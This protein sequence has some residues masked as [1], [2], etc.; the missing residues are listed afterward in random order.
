MS[1][2][3]PINDHRLP[4]GG[5]IDRQRQK[6]FVF[7]GR[8]YCGYEGDTLAS[9]LLANGVHLAGR[10]F[11]YHR[12]RGIFSDGPE[13]PNALVEMRIG[14]RR[15]PNTRATMVELYDG[16][17]ANS[18][19]R[20]PALSFDLQA[21]NQWLSPG[22]VAGFYYKTF[23]WPKKGWMFYEH[24]IR[25]AAGLG[26]ATLEPD[27][28]L[29]EKV[30]AHCDVLVIGGGPAGIAA[31][32]AAGRAGARV[33]LCDERPDLGGT[34]RYEEREIDGKPAL[35][36]AGGHLAELAGMPDVTVLRRTTAFGTY[37]GNTVGLV[38]RVSDHL[39]TP[40]P[41][42]VRQR[43]WTVRAKKIVLATGAIERPLVF[44]NNDKPGV[45]LAS[46][47]R[48]YIRQY[49]VKPGERAVLFATN[50][51]AYRT[52][53]ALNEAGAGVTV[54]DPRGEHGTAW[55]ERVRDAGIEVLTGHVITSLKGRLRV[56]EV[57][58][59]ESDGRGH[60]G[61]PRP[62]AADLV[63]V[64]G[65]WAPTL[66]LATHAGAKAT[67]DEERGSFVPD[68]TKCRADMTVVGSANG[69]NTLSGAIEEGFATGA[70]AA[71][72]VGKSAPDPIS[73]E[74]DDPAEAP[75]RSLWKVEPAQGQPSKSFV[76]L[77]NDATAKD[78]EIANREGYI[79]VEHMKRYTT[80]GMATDQGKTANVNGLALLAEARGQSIPDV[81]TTTFRPPYTPVTLGAM[82]GRHTAKHYKPIRRT[83]MH[84]WHTDAGAVFVE[85]GLWLRPQYYPRPGED[86]HAAMRREVKMTRN[87]VGLCDV[88]TLGKID[89][90]GPDAAEF[91]NR[92]YSNGFKTLAVGKARYGLMLREDGIVY[93]DGTTSRLGEN[94]YLMTTTTGHAVEVM[95]LL[96][97]YAQVLW[98]ELDVQLTSVT[99][100]WAAIAVAGPK[101]R[102]V[103]AD[104][105][106]GIDFSNQGLPFMGVAD[107]TLDGVP[108]RVFRIS[109]SGD[110]AYEIQVPADHGHQAWKALMAAGEAHD[111][112]PYG[113][114]AL[115]IMR[116]EKGFVTHAEIDGRT[117]PG[118]LGLDKM[119]SRKKSYIGRFLL[120]REALKDPDR[121]TLIGLRPVDGKATIRAGSILVRDPV[122]A[123]P[124]DM[125]GHVTSQCY[126]PT[127]GE[128]IALALLKNGPNRIGE[129]IWATFP[130]YNVSV[131]CE[132]TP[133]VRFD[134]DGSKVK[135]E[136]TDA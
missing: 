89:I 82:V 20:F 71:K 78:I 132:I 17:I 135:G 123:G 42:Q 83:P 38:E 14:A 72:A 99:D 77:Q 37:D 36:W 76:D 104:A 10:S 116:I 118:D 1:K 18:Q 5:L 59:M 117:T 115:N 23:M 95:G 97:Y 27:P 21:V 79:S 41:F 2:P 100:H 108:A 53:L 9:A 63:A 128:P 106:A 52:A 64:S 24:I 30:H 110:L 45:M 47:V 98:P 112:C 35:D 102:T 13:E 81:G 32:L 26:T 73:V 75:V 56:K 6:S 133:T 101:S 61:S 7:D 19:N 66:H 51:D 121:P 122:T 129:T 85:A 11:K 134:P 33:M 34:L 105:I 62:I 50:D 25:H 74:V 111:I 68:M 125:E 44:P 16:L 55:P 114:E 28:D 80:L 54:V 96:E 60:K 119:A 124:D 29:Y 103:L 48:S 67:W 107:G 65:G 91:L 8:R 92:T 131:Q 113:M 127:F 58:A 4:T 15:E 86:V 70:A 87:G 69:T 3:C 84:D 39:P 90:Q 120:E 93:D 126:S 49:G 94:H 130:L 46:A 136:T 12:P 31:A 88:S 22:L 57:L 40:A 43:M 109:F